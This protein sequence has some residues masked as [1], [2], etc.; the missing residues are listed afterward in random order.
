MRRMIVEG[1]RNIGEKGRQTV[2]TLVSKDA[3]GLLAYKMLVC[4]V[5]T[6]KIPAFSNK[7]FLF[8][9]TSY[10]HTLKHPK[11]KSNHFKLP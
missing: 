5:A 4:M 1:I 11:Q 3:Y 9:N 8:L 2:P 6:H 10:I 7:C